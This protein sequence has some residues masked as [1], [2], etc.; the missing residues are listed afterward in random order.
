[1]HRLR[2]ES[3]REGLDVRGCDRKR[4]EFRDIPNFEI[5]AGAHHGRPEFASGRKPEMHDVTI[6]DHV[7]LAFQT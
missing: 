1:M 6:S 3:R 4:P 2:I 5:L 7:F